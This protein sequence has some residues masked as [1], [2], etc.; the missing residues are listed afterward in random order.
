MPILA[1]HRQNYLNTSSSQ[2]TFCGQQGFQIKYES[3]K[4]I[5]NFMFFDMKFFS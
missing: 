5:F 2:A 3:P 1:R 4:I